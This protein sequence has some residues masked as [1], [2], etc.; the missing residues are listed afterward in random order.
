MELLT[1]IDYGFSMENNFCPFEIEQSWGKVLAEELQKP[2]LLQLAAFVENERRLGVPIYPSKEL[3]FN[4]FKLTPYSQVKVVIMGQDPYHGPGQAHG[5]CFSVPKGVP[6]PPSLVN[7]F[8]ELASDV[9]I[10]MPKHGCLL[11][12]AEQGI[13]LLNA[14][15]TVQ[16]GNP[17]SHH[18]KGWER[19]TDAII[20]KLCE[21]EE[22]IIF[23]LWG[24]SA[25]EKGAQ[26][27][28]LNTKH[29]LL[30][31]AH[32][33][34]LSAHQGFFGCKH[35]SKINDLLIQQNKAEITWNLL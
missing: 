5:L 2:Y 25:K 10:E 6:S 35:F 22:P 24:K 29:I 30:A 20:A 27:K 9:R 12:W 32:P 1:T 15:L 16:Q 17:M 8:K 4:A 26:V 13:L 18:G 28:Q 11:S 7:I 33:S 3:V 14:T 19:F 23:V 34:P 21:R 31:A